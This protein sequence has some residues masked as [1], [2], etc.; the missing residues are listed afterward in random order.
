MKSHLKRL[1]MPKSWDLKRKK[2]VYI[3]RSHPGGYEKDLTMPL[4]VLLRNVLGFAKTAKEVRYILNHKTIIVNGK[5]RRD[6]KFP[7]G[8]M[9][10][11]DCP[12]LKKSY[13]VSLNQKGKLIA[14]EI[15]GAESNLKVQ[16][17]I[18]KKHL[19]KGKIQLNCDGGSNIIVEKDI[20]KTG[21]VIMIDIKKNKIDQHIKL[22]KACTAFLTGGKRVGEVAK[23]EAIE[24]KKISLKTKEETF[25]TLTKYALAIGKEKPMVTVQ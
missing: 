3:M 8:L 21:E 11:L 2:T 20:Y 14:V 10:I 6:P 1:A 25:E 4:Q 7:V 13:R 22:E 24:D 17:I 19:E 9:D 16:K 12:D 5:Q 23:V 18:G 15:S